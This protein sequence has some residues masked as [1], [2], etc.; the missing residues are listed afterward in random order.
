MKHRGAVS[1]IGLDG[2]PDGVSYRAPTVLITIH[3]ILDISVCNLRPF[4]IAILFVYKDEQ[5]ATIV[6]MLFKIMIRLKCTRI[7]IMTN[8]N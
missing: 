6:T 8:I 3:L 7:Y 1:G 5:N 4:Y 2:S